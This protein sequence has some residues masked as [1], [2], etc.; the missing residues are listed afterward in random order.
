[1]GN[2]VKFVGRTAVVH[3]MLI[4]AKGDVLKEFEKICPNDRSFERMKKDMH[5]IFDDL[6]RDL[7]QLL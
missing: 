3:D 7:K 5:D 1:M 2:E 6:E 4:K